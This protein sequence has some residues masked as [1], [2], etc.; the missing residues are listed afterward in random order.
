MKLD[1]WKTKMIGFGCDGTNAN[2]AQGG[3][4]GLLTREMPWVFVFWCLSHHLELT[5]KDTLKPTFFAMVEELL[6]RLYYI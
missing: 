6:L 3:F 4:R 2:F 5:V 1:K